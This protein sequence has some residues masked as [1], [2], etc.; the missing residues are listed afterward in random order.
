[1]NTEQETERTL[2]DPAAVAESYRVA[3]AVGKQLRLRGSQAAATSGDGSRAAHG[4]H[5]PLCP[6]AD[7]DA[8]AAVDVSLNAQQLVVPPDTNRTHPIEKHG[9]GL[10]LLLLLLLFRILVICCIF[11]A[12]GCHSY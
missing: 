8:A 1:V 5:L 4:P 7:R 2:L 3:H 9:Q 6:H 11:A 10:R 12:F